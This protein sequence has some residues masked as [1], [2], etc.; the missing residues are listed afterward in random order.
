MTTSRPSIPFLLDLLRL[1]QRREASAIYI[2]PWMPP[3]VRIDERT[4]PLSSV[5]FTPEQSA[6]LVRD[7]LDE[8]Q[9]ASLDRSREIQFSLEVPEIGRLRVHA[10]RRHGQP[11]VAIRP[12][13]L[14]VPTAQSLALPALA[15]QAAMGERGLLVLT[16]RSGPLRRAVA[17]A[18][19]DH[20]NRHGQ[21]DIALLEEATR[22]WHERVR[23]QVRHGVSPGAVDEL[24]QRRGHRHATRPDDGGALMVG[25]GEL[26]DGAR[27]ADA[28][29][30]ADRALSMVVLDSA[31][32]ESALLR[33]MA[34]ADEI[35]GDLRRRLALALHMVLVLRP[36]PALA[37]R[38]DL[39][40][41]DA[42]GN[43]PELAATLTEGDR[44]ALLALLGGGGG[45][46]PPA[47]GAPVL[48]RSGPDEHLWQL[49]AQGLVDA[50][51]A[52]RHADDRQAFEARR[53]RQG[54]DADV[55]APTAPVRVDTGFADLFEE[56][57]PP[58]DPFAF[59]ATV[60]PTADTQFD[61]VDWTD[62]GELRT[63][64]LQQPAASPDTVEFHAWAP[65]AVAPGSLVAIDIWAGR[66]DQS[67][68][69]AT[70][71]RRVGARPPAA[72]GQA[73]SATPV[74]VQ[75]R[76]DGV[77][78]GAPVQRLA[79]AGRPDRVRFTVA[80]PSKAAEGAHAARV[81]LSV[82]GL[83][84]GELGFVLRVAADAS[85][86]AALEDTHAARRMLQTA[87]ASYA[88]A[89][90]NHVRECLAEMHRV[91]PTL[92]VY[93]DAPRL[94][95]GE[96]WRERIEREALRRERLFLFWSAAAA[97]SPWVDF[98]WRLTLRRRGPAA[99]DAVLLEPPRLAPLPPDLAD[100]SSL[101]LR[102]RDRAARK[103]VIP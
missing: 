28:V 86:A 36:V 59:T 42:L 49:V 51:V 74:N 11:A 18:L 25:W 6:T 76:I 65:A 8:G 87:Y 34:L 30:V 63:L 53:T 62:G 47:A 12:F 20:R 55:D 13:S 98:E 101:E 81:R 54:S 80:V 33:L 73:D 56:T 29:R 22:H 61:S 52:T 32:A 14:Q 26:R 95:H 57:A 43:S 1:A 60:P 70:Q 77:L 16:S 90:V 17:A 45:A 50:E 93:L 35:D 103:P 89:D 9:R 75:L 92:D 37:D 39:A 4:V 23:C 85:A 7:L 79:W 72:A 66:V 40:A 21:G 31:S 82:G 97:E 27:L 67:D 91:A 94:R 58:A 71:A 46:S 10:F 84:N 5:A 2:V 88:S 96:Q 19:V 3:T 99:I 83:P 69:V 78:D 44:S 41:T 48:N 24:V 100:V 15:C 68:T 102:L 64:P 38:R